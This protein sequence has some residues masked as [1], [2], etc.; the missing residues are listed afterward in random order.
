M[1]VSSP[2][3]EKVLAEYG[4]RR[5]LAGKNIRQVLLDGGQPLGYLRL[6]S[7]QDG[8]DLRF[9]GLTFSDFVSRDNLSVDLNR[10]ITAVKRKS[11]QH[12][13]DGAALRAG[14][15]SLMNKHDPWDVCCGHDLIQL[16]SIGLRR[17]F[18]SCKAGEVLPRLIERSLRL[19]YERTHFAMTDL[20]A[21]LRAWESAN[22]PFTVLP[23]N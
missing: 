23:K 9:E 22:T 17:Y 18:G 10:M 7:L 4:S 8:L 12:T 6:I 3:L 21:A 1:L 11:G 2:A 15:T 20:Y 16:L 13:L 5:K 19:A 14:I